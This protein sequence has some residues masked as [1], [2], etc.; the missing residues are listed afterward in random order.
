MAVDS[1][2]TTTRAS[3]AGMTAL[4]WLLRVFSLGMLLAALA[5]T[6]GPSGLGLLSGE[7][8]RTWTPTRDAVMVTGERAQVAPHLADPLMDQLRAQV[9]SLDDRSTALVEASNASRGN[10][11]ERPTD[12]AEFNGLPEVEVTFWSP[13]TGQQTS[14]V[15]T[16]AIPALAGA[17]GL[18]ILAAL[19]RSAAGGDPFTSRNVRRL[20]WLT[21]LVLVAGVVGDWGREA[22]RLWLIE[23]SDL[24]ADTAATVEVS[25]W[26]LG[27][28]AVLGV[29][30]AVWRRGVAMRSDLE[31]LV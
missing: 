3:S 29:I 12:L 15:A 19:V 2:S 24:A 25:W 20:S 17:A 23:T 9:G 31:G 1:G 5:L 14:Y 16:R 27:V 11:D 6:I 30:T 7:Y 26:W 4:A 28:A 8:L 18:W 22:V 10:L 21:G 13:S